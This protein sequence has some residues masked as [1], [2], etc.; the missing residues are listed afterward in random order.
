MYVLV[1]IYF[2]FCFVYQNARLRCVTQ[3]LIKT[4]CQDGEAKFDVGLFP[5]NERHRAVRNSIVLL[6]PCTDKMEKNPLGV[7]V[8]DNNNG[9]RAAE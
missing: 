5:A 6:I 2:G 9:K 8:D 3:I 1:F 7:A 4:N